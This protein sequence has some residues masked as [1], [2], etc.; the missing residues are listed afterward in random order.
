MRGRS[1]RWG[2]AWPSDRRRLASPRS[3]DRQIIALG[4]G[5]A[6]S[7]RFI[8]IQTMR[9][10]GRLVVPGTGSLYGAIWPTPERLVALRAG[11]EPEV[12]VVDPSARRVLERQ[13]LEGQAVGALPAGRR[14]VT[15]LEPKGAIGQ[16]RLAVIDEHA[17]VRT[18]P[19]PGVE[20]G[21][22]APTT[23]RDVLRQA[24]PG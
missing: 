8:D 13:P 1:N 15:L 4:S 10:T 20:A 18:L 14:L 3:P 5:T 2:V 11:Q 19:L 12:L 21:F 22:T 9:A 16:A 7:L 24:S 17:A 23:E 6:A